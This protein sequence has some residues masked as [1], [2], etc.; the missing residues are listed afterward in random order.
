MS[1]EREIPA[2][3]SAFLS[4]L[5]KELLELA[6]RPSNV[7]LQRNIASHLGESLPDLKNHRDFLAAL[8]YK[9]FLDDILRTS[10]EDDNVSNKRV[11]ESVRNLASSIRAY[12]ENNGARFIDAL[13][14]FAQNYRQIPLTR[15]HLDEIE[16]KYGNISAVICVP[17]LKAQKIYIGD[18]HDWPAF[19]N[20]DRNLA[21]PRYSAKI[22]HWYADTVKKLRGKPSGVNID[23]LCFIEKTYS[24]IGALSLMPTLVSQIG[25]PATVY[26]AGYWDKGARITGDDP[27]SGTEGCFIYDVAIGGNALLEANAFLEENYGLKNRHAVVFFEYD[28]PEASY[29]RAR[30]RLAG[31]GIELISCLKYSEV[32]DQIEAKQVFVKS[33]N[34]IV[35]KYPHID[36]DT[37]NSKVDKA[38]NEYADSLHKK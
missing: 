25:I 18:G 4:W 9:L 27:L 30:E 15:H 19:A 35:Q 3:E 33:M 11:D 14:E 16:V 26:R 1:T 17:P 8:T 38:L 24:G 32:R 34:H 5:K 2:Q 12:C 29:N 36:R 10:M 21:D 7:Q 20:L 13:L 28:V 31:K 22:S 23:I 6:N 37:Y